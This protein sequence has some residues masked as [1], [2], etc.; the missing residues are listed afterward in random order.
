MSV[1]SKKLFVDGRTHGRAD[2]HL[3][4]TLL[5]RGVDLKN[6][7]FNFSLHVF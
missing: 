1:K 5:R 7:E 4:L 2:G 6:R 3:R